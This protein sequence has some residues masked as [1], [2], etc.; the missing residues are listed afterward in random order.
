MMTF[1]R[2]LQM[3]GTGTANIQMDMF[4][5]KSNYEYAVIAIRDGYSEFCKAEDMLYVIVERK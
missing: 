2:L 5:T 3:H 4:I 1:T